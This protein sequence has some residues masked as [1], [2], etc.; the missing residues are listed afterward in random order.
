[1]KPTFARIVVAAGFVVAAMCVRLAVPQVLAHD[2]G[3]DSHDRSDPH[4]VYAAKVL[5]PSD[6][7]VT[8]TIN[9]HNPNN[10][11]QTVTKKG[12]A[13]DVGQVSTAPG[14]PVQQSLNPDWAFQMGCADLVALGAVGP[15]GFGDA[16]LESS[17][18]LDVWPVYLT[19]SASEGPP[20]AASALTVSGVEVVRVPAS[21][22]EGTGGSDHH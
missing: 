13:L 4:V 21:R 2:N 7:T 12:I 5:C 11:K 6:G 22:V 18:E 16:I 19:G 15:A 20:M 3:H 8:T 1:M 9:V 14:T 17:R 10:E